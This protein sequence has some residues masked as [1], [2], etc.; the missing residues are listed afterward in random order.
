MARVGGSV[1]QTTTPAGLSGEFP[2]ATPGLGPSGSTKVKNHPAHA[3][4]EQSVGS[5]PAQHTLGEVR[6]STGHRGPRGPGN[7]GG[8]QRHRHQGA[9][10]KRPRECR[11]RAVECKTAC[12]TLHERGL[13]S[14]HGKN[15]LLERTPNR[16]PRR[17]A[18]L[19]KR[20]RSSAIVTTVVVA[21]SEIKQQSS[22][23]P[24]NPVS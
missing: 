18:S 1:D 17:P 8:N 11:C 23:H 2:S 5:G 9:A 15:S 22:I 16:A 12:R 3:H 13:A 7:C 20:I 10:G 24:T 14:H 19:S 21:I 4:C 6:G